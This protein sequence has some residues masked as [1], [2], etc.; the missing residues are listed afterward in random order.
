MT[1]KQPHEYLPQC[2]KCGEDYPSGEGKPIPHPVYGEMSSEDEWLWDRMVGV[3]WTFRQ[4]SCPECAEVTQTIEVDL[5]TLNRMTDSNL[6]KA[7]F[8]DARRRQRLIHSEPRSKGQMVVASPEL[9]LVVGDS[10]MLR[11]EAV[12]KLWKY[13][14]THGLQHPTEKRYITA[15]STLGPVFGMSQISMFDISEVLYK[16]LK[17]VN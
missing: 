15:D 14:Q 11:T 13:I 8:V 10:E 12:Q 7:K 6:D 4:W 3:T 5:R 9:A 17:V 1:I 2:P 16:H